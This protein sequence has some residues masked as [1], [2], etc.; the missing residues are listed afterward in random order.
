MLVFGG[1]SMVAG[2]QAIQKIKSF[3]KDRS[4][5]FPPMTPFLVLCM[6]IFRTLQMPMYK[7]HACKTVFFE[8]QKRIMSKVRP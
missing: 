5:F 4:E 6:K 3:Q 1:V 7:I 2:S 8:A